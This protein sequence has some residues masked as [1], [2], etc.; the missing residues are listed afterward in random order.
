MT[1]QNASAGVTSNI[2]KELRYRVFILRTFLMLQIS[3]SY[4]PLLVTVTLLLWG[5]CYFTAN[6][7]FLKYVGWKLSCWYHCLL[8]SFGFKTIFPTK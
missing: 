8:Y 4:I 1:R 6:F 3:Y 2:C 5:R 7:L